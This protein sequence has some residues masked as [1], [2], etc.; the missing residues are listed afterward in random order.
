MQRSAR[1]LT[2]V[3]TGSKR[4]LAAASTGGCRKGKQYQVTRRNK[5]SGSTP[6]MLVLLVVAGTPALG[7]DKAIDVTSCDHRKK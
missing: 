4:S 6:E 5:K 2:R 3:R 1:L 7:T